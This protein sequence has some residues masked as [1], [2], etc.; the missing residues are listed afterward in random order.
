M[1]EKERIAKEKELETARL[2]AQQEKAA[3]KQ[4]ELD[5]LRARRYQEAKE[6]EWRARELA[7]QEHQTS[8]MHHLAKV[9]ES[10]KAAKIRQLADMARVEQ[11]EF[12]RV[13]DANRKKEKDEVQQVCSHLAS[14]PCHK[15]IG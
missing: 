10:Q 12:Q 5:E 3:D 2:R 14:L 11:R 7:A 15:H 13:L 6:R 1:A 8:T 4:A 9:R